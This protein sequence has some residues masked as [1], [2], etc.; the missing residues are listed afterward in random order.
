MAE[1][2]GTVAMKGFAEATGR[3]AA[4]ASAAHIRN[5]GRAACHMRTY[6]IYGDE[7]KRSIRW[8][9]RP[10]SR[11]VPVHKI[12]LTQRSVHTCLGGAASFGACIVPSRSHVSQRVEMAS[13]EANDQTHAAQPKNPE[14]EERNQKEMEASRD[15]GQHAQQT[16]QCQ[17]QQHTHETG[18]GQEPAGLQQ[19]HEQPCAHG[20]GQS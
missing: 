13:E 9:H 5:A 8:R 15:L 3:L 11:V 6:G 4:E 2:G 18:T 7:E 10:A 1:S 16:G 17:P 20:D 12:V 19:A 14:V